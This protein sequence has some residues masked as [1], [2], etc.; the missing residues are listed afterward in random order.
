MRVSRSHIARAAL[1][2]LLVL[3]LWAALPGAAHGAQLDDVP[4][5]GYQDLQFV[6][7]TFSFLV[8]GALVMWMCAGFTMLESGSVRTKNASMICL[9]NVGIFSIAALAYFFVGYN[10]MYV[11]VDSVVGTLQFLYASRQSW[12]E[13]YFAKGAA[14]FP[15]GPLAAVCTVVLAALLL[16]FDVSNADIWTCI[17][18]TLVISLSVLMLGMLVGNTA[19][20]MDDRLLPISLATGALLAFTGITIPPDSLPPGLYHLAQVLPV[21]HGLPALREG[22]TGA[23]L[24]EVAD[25]LLLELGIALLYAVVGAVM[26]ALLQ[27]EALRRG[28]L[29][30]DA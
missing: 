2:A 17:V 4:P 22:F 14:H 23:G 1:A 28:T 30:E 11:D 20:V 21:T 9:K 8:W 19:M 26:F 10:L 25:S 29:S 15:N 18:A 6:L 24:R 16:D 7:N 27:R 5:P 13:A 12:V 3:G